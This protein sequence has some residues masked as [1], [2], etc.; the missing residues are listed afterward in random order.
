MSFEPSSPESQTY[1]FPPTDLV[2]IDEVAYSQVIETSFDG[3][4]EVRFILC[5]FILLILFNSYSSAGVQLKLLS[6]VLFL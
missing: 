5:L 4:K 3:E 6:D 2:D 1:D